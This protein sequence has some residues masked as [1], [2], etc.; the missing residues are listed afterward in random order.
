MVGMFTID[1]VLGFTSCTMHYTC[2]Y[3][4]DRN[5]RMG[6]CDLVISS[7][8]ITRRKGRGQSSSKKHIRK[9]LCERKSREPSS[10]AHMIFF[11]GG[12]NLQITDKTFFR[13]QSHVY[14]KIKD[15]FR[16]DTLLTQMGLFHLRF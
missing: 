16:L 1:I 9:C 5:T 12:G 8:T 14:Q 11:L 10:N 13:W 3:F 2:S 15:K 4:I 7:T 6:G